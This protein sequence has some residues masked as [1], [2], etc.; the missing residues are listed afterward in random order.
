MQESPPKGVGSVNFAVT[1]F[2]ISSTSSFEWWALRD[3]LNTSA[4][5]LV[6]VAE[7]H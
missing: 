2:P 3:A 7:A 5:L 6:R 1:L 4:I